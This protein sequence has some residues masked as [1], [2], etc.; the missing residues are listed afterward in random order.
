MPPLFA[1]LRHRVLPLL[2]PLVLLAACHRQ[3]PEAAPD[4]TV[5]VI[6]ASSRELPE[7][8]LASGVIEAAD[9]AQIGFLVPGRV[10]NVLVEEGASVVAGQPL[11][12]LDDSDLRN[13]AAIADAHLNEARSRHER[14]TQLHD[15][16]SL[17]ATDFDKS[18]AAFK[19]AESAAELAHRHLGY[20]ELQAPFAGRVQRQGLNVGVVAVPGVPLCTVLASAPVWASLS[21]PEADAPRLRSG[22]VASIALAAT[23]SP[24]VAGTIE[25]I[26]PQADALTRSF[27]VR[28]RLANEDGRFRVGNVI[29]GRLQT[30][31]SRKV[32]LLPPAVVQRFPDGALFVWVV[33]AAHPTASRRI[34]TA[35]RVQETGIE[36]TSGLQAGDRV[37]DSGTT[38]LHDGMA[39]QI[40]TP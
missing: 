34:V 4:P 10:A 28:V 35:G 11:A 6:V 18:L 8:I 32:I 17:T 22:L 27:A 9:K 23:D 3:V 30:G 33:E 38:P 37:I 1:P 21:V 19:E 15:A 16:G 25:A 39:V 13:E 5:R 36:I 24:S 7:E 31:S 20:A 12:R 29:T 2:A 40:A 14:L 26:L